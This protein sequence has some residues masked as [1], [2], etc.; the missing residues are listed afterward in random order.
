MQSHSN[1]W[2]ETFQYL[3]REMLVPEVIAMDLQQVPTPPVRFGPL[4]RFLSHGANLTLVCS[5]YRPQIVSRL[6]PGRV[7]PLSRSRP[8]SFQ[9]LS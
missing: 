1:D 4:P 6:I 7:R 8:P 3:S 9:G 5:D 2:D